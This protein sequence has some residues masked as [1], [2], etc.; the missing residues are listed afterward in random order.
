MKTESG[1]EI[2]GPWVDRAITDACR[3]ALPRLA[4]GERLEIMF[5]GRRIAA[6]PDPMRWRQEGGC[7]VGG[8]GPF[9]LG[10]SPE[11]IGHA[12]VR[13]TR[14]EAHA[15]AEH[16]SPLPGCGP[17]VLTDTYGVPG[18]YGGHIAAPYVDEMGG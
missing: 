15:I 10:D 1:R 2:S 17:T 8:E 13:L 5:A 16:G 11:W 12:V 14:D 3:A 7:L 6:F 18:T 9:W 4:D